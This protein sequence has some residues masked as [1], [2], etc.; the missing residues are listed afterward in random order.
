MSSVRIASPDSPLI[1][2]ATNALAD[3]TPVRRFKRFIAKVGETYR[4]KSWAEPLRITAERAEHW[5]NTFAEMNRDGIPVKVTSDHKDPTKAENSMGDVV[6]IG[7]ENGWIFTEQEVRGQKNIEIAEANKDVSMEIFGAVHGGNGK[8]YRD[9]IR[10][11]TFTPIPV[12]YGQPI[13]ASMADDDETYF[14]SQEIEMKPIFDAIARLAGVDAATVTEANAVG[15]LEK[16]AGALKASLA[17][18]Q[19]QVLKLSQDDQ[20]DVKYLSM[21]GRFGEQELSHAVEIGDLSPACADEFKEMF[22]G[23]RE[24]GKFSPLML[25]MGEQSPDMLAKIL[26]I[27]KKNKPVPTGGTTHYQLLNREVPDGNGAKTRKIKNPI[28]GQDCEVAA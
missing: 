13:A 1:L 27:I 10:A 22:V 15:L 21:A 28:T 18:A 8:V 2:S 25:S 12:V 3:G 6:N 26:K 14:L 19:A 5:C 4:K 11:V 7:R 9:A 20:P 17:D 16:H 23:D 24:G